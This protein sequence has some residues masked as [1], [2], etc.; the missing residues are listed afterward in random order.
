MVK[1]P[2][3]DLADMIGQVGLVLSLEA[4]LCGDEIF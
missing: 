3:T 1:L 2:K 4:H